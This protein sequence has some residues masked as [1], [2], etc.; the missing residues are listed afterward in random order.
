MILF[1]AVTFA[2]LIVFLWEGWTESSV[3]EEMRVEL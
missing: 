1:A 3:P 2:A